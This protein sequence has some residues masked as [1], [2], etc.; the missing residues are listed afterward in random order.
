ANRASISGASVTIT[1]TN[2][3][4]T[5]ESGEPNHAGNSGGK[6]VWWTWTAPSTGSVQIDTIGSN[7]DTILGVYTGSSVSSLTAVSGGSD[8][9]SGGNLTSKVIFNVVSG[10]I[11]Q[12]AVDGYSARSGNI[13]VHVSWTTQADPDDQIAEAQDLGAMT[14][15]RSFSGTIDAV[16]S[17]GVDVDM[18]SFTVAGGQRIAFDI[19]RP[20]D[21]GIANSYIRL[22]GSSGSELA[23]NDNGPAP[24]EGSTTESYFEY[25]FNTAGTYYIGVSGYANT[26][27]NPVSGTSDAV[28]GGTGQYTLVLTPITQTLTAI[29]GVNRITGKVAMPNPGERRTDIEV[30]LQRVDT[31][32]AF[33]GTIENGRKT[34]I[35]IHG[36][37]S[38]P[39]G[40]ARHDDGSPALAAVIDGYDPGD[41]VLVLGWR[42]GAADNW[43][44]DVGL[45][46]AQWIP[47]VADWAAG[48]LGRIGL[49]GTSQF[50]VG[51]SWGSLIAYEMGARVSGGVKALVALDP[52]YQGYGYDDSAVNFDRVSAWSWAFYG[53]G[54]YGSAGKSGTANEA[55]AIEYDGWDPLWGAAHSAPIHLF[56]SLVRRNGQSSPPARASLFGLGKLEG[57]T[58]GPWALN[59]YSY[60][61]ADEGTRKVFEGV[62]GLSDADNDGNW[63][64]SWD[65]VLSFRYR[66]AIL[67]IIVTV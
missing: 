53:G 31:T 10:T 24:R 34:W 64:D 18:Y 44:A 51:H 36:R 19:D 17:Y 12:I 56:E 2:V 32:G 7:F 23:A 15:V 40:F 65:Q 1:G 62:F 35:V 13:T 37:A 8:D 41:Q 58:P 33:S 27:Y 57:A 26:A 45:Q 25:L 67:N 38:S 47:Y 66:H 22:F 43:P 54:G 4:A 14:Q 63:G 50:L 30:S 60:G 49:A 5:K 6:S 11:Y 52:A 28:N 16:A 20:G 29:T 42:D 61:S 3:G 46:G 21:G 55:F 48:V 9:D 39:E 59:E